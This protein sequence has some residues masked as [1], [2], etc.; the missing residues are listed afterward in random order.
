MWSIFS[1]LIYVPCTSSLLRCLLRSLCLWPIILMRFLFP[2]C[3]VLTDLCVVLDHSPLLDVSLANTFSLTAS[4][5]RVEA[6]NFILF[7]LFLER[8]EQRERNINVW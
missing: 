6:C 5:P 3:W 4:F 7:C 8:W 2:Y 1:W